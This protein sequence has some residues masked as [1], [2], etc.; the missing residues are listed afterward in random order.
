MPDDHG[1][2]ASIGRVSEQH[3]PL[4]TVYG[5]GQLARMMQP[6]AAELDIHLRVLASAP[7]KSAA[8]V[9]PDVVLG[10]YHDLDVLTA[11]A[12]GADAITFEHEHVPTEHVQTLIADGLNVQPQPSALLYAQDKLLMRQKMAELGAPVPR[13]AAIESV[14]DARDFAALVDGSVCLKARRGGYDGHGVWFPSAEELEPLVAKLLAADTPLMAEEKVN[15]TREL[16]VLVA[17]RPSGEV[18]V[19]PVTESVQ[20]DGICAEAFAPAPNLSPELT[21]RAMQVGIKVATELG[22][23][24][25]LAVELFAFATQQDAGSIIASASGAPGAV[26]EEDIAV[27]ELAMRPHNTGHWTQD[28]CV[29][30]Q[31]EQHLRAVLDLP[32]GSTAALAPVTVMANVLGAEEDPQ[33]PMPQRVREVMERYPEAKVHLYG[34]DHKPG[35]KIGHVNVV[36]E[37]VAET[38]RIAHDAAH[39]LV[40]A[41]WA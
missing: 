20:R 39:F 19:W 18:K 37:D 1:P 23:T 9:I 28:G 36:G 41:Q 27:N 4:V 2:K 6:A 22:V 3:K 8:Q 14:E 35:R 32:L 30:S 34:K 24:G 5:D 29:T 38:R 21:E 16:S 33:M 12:D 7:D 15:L 26:V 17:R 11:A 10:D 40:H 13:F 31:F 25:V